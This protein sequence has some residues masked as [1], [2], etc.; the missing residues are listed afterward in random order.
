MHNLSISLAI[1][2]Q[3][4]CGYLVICLCGSMAPTGGSVTPLDPEALRCSEEAH[5]LGLLCSQGTAG[6]VP[7]VSP[8]LN[9]PLPG[10]RAPP[11]L[12]PLCKV[13]KLET[14]GISELYDCCIL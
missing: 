7:P 4:A 10:G 8:A 6:N 5:W 11:F 9:V 14:L 13:T 12:C 3:R 1:S 2:F